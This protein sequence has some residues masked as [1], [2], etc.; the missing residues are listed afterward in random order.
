MSGMILATL[1]CTAL[2]AVEPLPSADEIIDRVVKQEDVNYERAKGWEYEQ[3]IAVQK[4]DGEGRVKHEE[5]KTITYRPEGRLS[6]N[7]AALKGQGDDAQVGIGMTN[8]KDSEE[9]GRFSESLKM[10]ELRPFYTFTRQEDGV[11]EGKMHWVVDFKPKPGVEAHGQQQKVLKSLMGRLW[12]DPDENAI[13]HADC[14]L[15][16]PIPFAWF[17]LV[18]LRELSIRYD[19]H[20]FEGKVWMPRGMNL[21]YRVRILFFGQ[22]YERQLMKADGFREISP[23]VTVADPPQDGAR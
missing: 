22:V 11:L 20:S 6:F 16:K 2:T 7:V 9:E 4:L 1:L 12:I 15:E 5:V 21:T 23:Q 18:T 14:S 13:A 8:E 3:H 10:R 17:D 19:A